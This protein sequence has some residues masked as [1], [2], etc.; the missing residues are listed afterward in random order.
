MDRR[1]RIFTPLTLLVLLLVAALS[2]FAGRLSAP[3][4]EEPEPQASPAPPPAPRPK[5]N[6]H[7][8]APAAPAPEPAGKAADDP[9]T[10]PDAFRGEWNRNLAHCGTG[11]NDSAMRVEPR[12]L[13]FYESIGRVTGVSREEERTVTVS[14]DF[15][16]EGETWSDRIR[17]TL[18]AD[19][20]QL[21]VGEDETRRRCP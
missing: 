5:E 6:G 11:L 9:A 1:N 4:R 13:R 2:F 20:R 8:A 15:E 21:S 17:L 19:G 10:I 3:Q 18:S 7:A 12:A 14:A 16:G